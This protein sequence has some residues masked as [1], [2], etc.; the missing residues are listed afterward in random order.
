METTVSTELDEKVIITININEVELSSMKVSQ[1][2]AQLEKRCC[3]AS[4]KKIFLKKTLQRILLQERVL[5]VSS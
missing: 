3:G 4:G 2:R 5:Q 1:L